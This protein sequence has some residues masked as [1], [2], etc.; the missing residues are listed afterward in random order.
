MWESKE[1]S[2][3][4]KTNRGLGVLK[5]FLFHQIAEGEQEGRPSFPMPNYFLALG[6]IEG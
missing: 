3:W 2:G 4:R 5:P 6:P 1:R